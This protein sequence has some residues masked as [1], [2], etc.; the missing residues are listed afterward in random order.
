MQNSSSK[1]KEKEKLTKDNIFYIS[2]I[3]KNNVQSNKINIHVI[4][5]LS[6]HKECFDIS[7]DVSVVKDE[8][9]NELK[10]N[11]GEVIEK[12]FTKVDKSS[13]EDYFL[14]Y[15]VNQTDDEIDENDIIYIHLGEINIEKN[16]YKNMLL[17]IPKDKKIYLK[18]R[19]K[20][21]IEKLGALDFF[22]QKE[23]DDLTTDNDTI[24]LNEEEE[25]E[26]K[27]DNNKSCYRQKEKTI[28]YAIL[29]VIRYEIIRKNSNKKISQ[30][31]ICNMIDI[32]KKA[33]DKYKENIQK[34]RENNFEFDRYYKYQVH[35]LYKFNEEKKKE[36]DV[37]KP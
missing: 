2:L 35:V 4:L 21:K 1:E 16:E 37:K 33:L 27:N 14:S 34:G 19:Q 15:Y 31:D 28:L 9:I 5:S 32:S 12:I 36:K 30:Y 11:M 26:E 13:R 20:I 29:K 17:K 18:L 3:S 24:K 22:K 6:Y 8:N 10:F 25:K 23:F 7:I